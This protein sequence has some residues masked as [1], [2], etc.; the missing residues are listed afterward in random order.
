MRLSEGLERCST[1]SA[2]MRVPFLHFS[3]VLGTQ[4]DHLLLLEVEGHGGGR[5][6]TGG[7]SVGREGTSVV[8]DIVGM[9][10]FKL[11]PRRADEHVAHE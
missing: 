3:S 10:V 11:F 1:P 4:D 6:H 9:E 5:G 8:D 7:I 2:V